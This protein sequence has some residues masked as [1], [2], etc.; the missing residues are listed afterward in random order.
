M[1]KMTIHYIL[2]YILYLFTLSPLFTIMIEYLFL[3]SIH[4]SFSCLM[5]FTSRVL[6]PILVFPVTCMKETVKG[7]FRLKQSLASSI[8]SPV[9]HR[10]ER[11]AGR[12]G[13]RSSVTFLMPWGQESGLE[14]SV[15]LCF[16]TNLSYNRSNVNIW[17]PLG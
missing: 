3:K 2:K 5:T 11:I 1:Y 9:K 8:T 13:R 16:E 12:N 15:S 10:A 7:Q 17:W 14:E 6:F 4:F